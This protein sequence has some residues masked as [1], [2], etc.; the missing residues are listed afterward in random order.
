VESAIAGEGY[1]FQPTFIVS[2]ALKK[3]KLNVI[4]EEFEPEPLALYVLFPHRRLIATKLSAF[5]EF[6]SNYYGE[7]PYWDKGL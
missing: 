3:G 1:V 5:I 7:S 2:D 6:L 4:L